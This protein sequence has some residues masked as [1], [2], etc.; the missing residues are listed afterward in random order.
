MS[1]HFANSAATSVAIEKE[2]LNNSNPDHAQQHPTSEIPCGCPPMV[3]G[4]APSAGWCCKPRFIRRTTQTT[5]MAD[6]SATACQLAA[7]HVRT[8]SP[9]AVCLVL[10]QARSFF[11]F[12]APSLLN[13]KW[14]N[15]C[16]VS[17]AAS[18]PCLSSRTVRRA[19]ISAP[20]F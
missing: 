8:L 14:R 6:G 9:I 13:K 20:S 11:C 7:G 19:R 12:Y 16:I 18:E 15:K 4:I 5:K 10:G 17:P 3:Q 2:S 1:H